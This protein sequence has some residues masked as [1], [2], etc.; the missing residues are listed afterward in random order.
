MN[1]FHEWLAQERLEPN[2]QVRCLEIKNQA[3]H[4]IVRFVANIVVKSLAF[5]VEQVELGVGRCKVD[6][7]SQVRQCMSQHDLGAGLP[8]EPNRLP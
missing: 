1:D 4:V 3:A 8:R 2:V 5:T 6:H 7:L